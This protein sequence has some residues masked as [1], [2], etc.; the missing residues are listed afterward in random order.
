MMACNLP[1]ISVITPSY[2]AG[3]YIRQCIQSVQDQNYPNFEHIIMDGGSSDG[4]IDI[5][6]EYP[7]LIW[8]SEQD[9]GEADALNKALKR[10]TGDIIGWLNAD[11]Y[12][13]EQTFA[14]VAHELDP[15]RGAHV[16]YGRVAFIGE[17]GKQ[18]RISD[19]SREVSFLRI[20]RWFRGPDL[21]QPAMFFSRDV[22]DQVGPFRSDLHYSVDYE[23]W[24]RMAL[25]YDFHF[26]DQVLA[27]ARLF[28]P[29][30]KSVGAWCDQQRSH[31]RVSTHFLSTASLPQRYAFWSEYALYRTR[32]WLRKG[33]LRMCIHQM[34]FRLGLRTR[35]RKGMAWVRN[36]IV[37]AP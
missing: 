28:R 24:L 14:R 29:G 13:N 5:L 1:K 3:R 30:S 4:T 19:P 17:D 15:E 36:S 6:E 27:T 8:Q 21:Q 37:R 33:G 31:Q 26:V 16:I 10:V 35:L 34:R 7:H 11:D 23:Y 20:L 25:H 9:E 12:Y 18:D 2:N 22:V 32:E